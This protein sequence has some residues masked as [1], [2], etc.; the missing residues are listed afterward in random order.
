MTTVQYPSLAPVTEVIALPASQP[1]SITVVGTL[2]DLS[3][4]TFVACALRSTPAA[5]PPAARNARTPQYRRERC[6][7]PRELSGNR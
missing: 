5:T 2:V 1:V 7:A 4:V 6:A 3:T